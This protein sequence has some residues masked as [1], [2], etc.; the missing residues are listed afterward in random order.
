MRLVGLF[1]EKDEKRLFLFPQISPAEYYSLLHPEQILSSQSLGVS[2]GFRIPRHL[3]I[4]ASKAQGECRVISHP[5]LPS[6]P[7]S[8]HGGP[9]SGERSH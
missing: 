1:T 2:L 9:M 5:L 6:W 3:V 8:R 7:V 4:S